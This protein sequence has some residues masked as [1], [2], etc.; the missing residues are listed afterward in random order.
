MIRYDANGTWPRTDLAAA[1]TD[2]ATVSRSVRTAPVHQRLDG[3]AP[4]GTSAR[5]GRMCFV[6]AHGPGSPWRWAA[7]RRIGHDYAHAI[8]VGAHQRSFVAE[9]VRRE[10]KSLLCGRPRAL[11]FRFST[12]RRR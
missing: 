6:M 11:A 1:D 4:D 12:W 10:G 3:G 7:S 2:V 8:A 9:R 5:W